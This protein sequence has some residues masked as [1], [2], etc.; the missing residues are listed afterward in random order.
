MLLWPFSEDQ[1]GDFPSTFPWQE[2]AE[3]QWKF[4]TC[5]KL[6]GRT[7]RFRKRHVV[8]LVSV[9]QPSSPVAYPLPCLKLTAKAPEK[10]AGLKKE[11]IGETNNQSSGAMLQAG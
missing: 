6:S 9:F 8:P 2:V 5:P 11:R 7:V 1:F 4:S 3:L 10:M